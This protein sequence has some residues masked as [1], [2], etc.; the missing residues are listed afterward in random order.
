MCD[1]GIE[2]DPQNNFYDKVLQ[3]SFSKIDSLSSLLEL[4]E[5]IKT[6]LK[7]KYKTHLDNKINNVK[8]IFFTDKVL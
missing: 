8:D 2:Y 7:D 6:T 3:N 5:T 4:D 1:C